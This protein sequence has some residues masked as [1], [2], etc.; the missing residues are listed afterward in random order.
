MIDFLIALHRKKGLPMP[1]ALPAPLKN[2]LVAAP[3]V[4]P[5]LPPGV[6]GAVPGAVPG[7]VPGAMPV[8]GFPPVGGPEGVA[9]GGFAPT[10]APINTASQSAPPASITPQK[11]PISSAFDFESPASDMTLPGHMATSHMS[12]R[13]PSAEGA[14]FASAAPAA[15]PAG[16]P[17]MPTAA[18]PVPANGAAPA[19]VADVS[20]LLYVRGAGY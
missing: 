12:V 16:L 14:G 9:G 8:P 5:T 19:A 15:A 17:P 6:P 11:A 3:A 10:P 13:R 7:V 1:P 2:F 20:T 4:P 18:A